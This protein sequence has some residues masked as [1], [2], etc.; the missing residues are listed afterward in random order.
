MGP[1]GPPL[2]GLGGVRGRDSGAGSSHQRSSGPFRLPTI[3]ATGGI[4]IATTH[5]A[6]AA[7]IDQSLTKAQAETKR[8]RQAPIITK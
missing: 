3:A 5:I 8:T 7:G 6:M 2:P 4:T 1:A